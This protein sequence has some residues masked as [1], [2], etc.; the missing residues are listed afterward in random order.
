MG[1]SELTQPVS[2]R[3][4][5][6]TQK[7]TWTRLQHDLWEA[8]KQRRE[9]HLKME[10]ASNEVQELRTREGISKKHVADLEAENAVL[11]VRL[12]DRVE[13]LRG[14]SK[15]LEVGSLQGSCSIINEHFK[16]LH[17]ESVAMNLQLNLLEERNVKLDQDNQQL[18]DRWMARKGQEADTMNR[19]LDP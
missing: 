8:Q 16:N 11:A 18:V 1:S 2:D 4:A 7:D 3:D 13:E 19:E 17:N 14:K 15:L 9:L 12:R 5:V 10:S 6:P